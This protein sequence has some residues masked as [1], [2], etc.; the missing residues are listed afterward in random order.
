MITAGQIN[1][2]Q[3][4]KRGIFLWKNFKEKRKKCRNWRWKKPKLPMTKDILFGSL[5]E[6]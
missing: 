4:S 3:R 6:S 5:Q 1:K 2:G